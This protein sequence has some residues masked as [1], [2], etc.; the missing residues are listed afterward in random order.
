MIA[1]VDKIRILTFDDEYEKLLKELQSNGLFM[2]S[3]FDDNFLTN[4][5]QTYLQK[6]SYYIELLTTKTKKEKFFKYSETTEAKFD[7]YEVAEKMIDEISDIHSKYE[8]YNKEKIS[9]EDELSSIKPYLTLDV[10]IDDLNNLKGYKYFIGK[11]VKESFNLLK[12]QLENDKY[13]Y[14]LLSEDNDSV[15]LIILVDLNNQNQIE[16]L[17]IKSKFISNNFN[18]YDEI[19][20]TISNKLNERL[21][22]ISEY[23]LEYEK[24]I[25][26][27][28][29]ERYILEIYYDSIFNKYLRESITANKTNKTLYIEGWIKATDISKLKS[30]LTNQ[31]AY[32]EI[33]VIE[34][35]ENE[36]VPTATNNNKFVKPFEAITNMFSVPNSNEIDPNPTMSFWYFLIFGIMM[37][38]IG[39]GILMI[40]LFSL[41]K[42][43]KKPKGDF[44]DLITIFIYSGFSTIFFG[45]LFGSFFG[46]TFDLFNL[47]GKLFGQNNWSS[48]VLEPITDP[49]PVLIV[50]IGIGVLHLITALIIKVIKEVKNKNY[51]SALSNG[52]SWILVLVGIVLY[53]SISKGVG[54]VMAITGLVILVIFSGAKKKGIPAKVMSGF[55][56]LYNI[57]GYLSD[58]LSYSRILALSLSSAVIA[59]TMNMLAGMVATNFIGYLFAIV[60]FLI[61]HV[62]NFAMGLLS[63]YVHD[64][65]LQYLEFFGKFYD[66]GGVIF[67]PL[68]YQFKYIDKVNKGE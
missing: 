39:Y 26:S 36:I 28:A 4:K 40:V 24:R 32:Y 45:I 43:F 65:R 31:I 42:K 55:G 63:A 53:V 56:S 59:F 9:I 29:K 14:Q 22:F 11:I 50:S 16:N 15:Y 60:I 49:L 13:I 34:K 33:E 41:F 61:G 5:Q 21:K 17:L 10:S 20:D 6:V 25:S 47:I 2:L 35:E 64:S 1:K 19:F 51:A 7:R 37:G 18:S 44:K 62:F 38:D 52:L 12:S 46:Y 67:K 3:K 23:N 66:G 30:S 58:V 54:L 48:I 68:A 57:T 8:E 27:Y